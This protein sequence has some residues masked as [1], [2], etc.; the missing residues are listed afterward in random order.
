M[1]RSIKNFQIFYSVVLFIVVLMMHHLTTFKNSTKMIFQS[2][3]YAIKHTHS[4]LQKDV[5]AL[6]RNCNHLYL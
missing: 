5:L 3:P 1:F 6:R 2:Q 4:L